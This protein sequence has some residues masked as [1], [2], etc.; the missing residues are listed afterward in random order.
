MVPLYVVRTD[1][2][3]AHAE[4]L[5]SHDMGK[6]CLRFRNPDKIDFDWSSPCCR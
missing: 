2:R 4:Q 1:V 3:D 6:G 5:K